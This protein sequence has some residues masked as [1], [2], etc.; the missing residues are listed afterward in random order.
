MPPKARGTMNKQ[1]LYLSFLLCATTVFGQ[2]ASRT[3]GGAVVY[4]DSL[5]EAVLAATGI[6]I[7]Q[8]DE[9]IL[10]ADVVLDEA[11]IIDEGK[12]IRLVSG[13]AIRTIYRSGNLIE[14]PVV[15]V[16]G[17]GASLTLGK[18]GMVYGLVIDGGFL[19]SPSIEAHCPLAAVSGVGAKLIMYDMVALQ[20]NKNI[21]TPS[22]SSHY[23]YGGGVYIRTEGDIQSRKAEFIMKG[24]TIRGNI[25]DVQNGLGS[26]GGV[27]I[28]GFGIF[29]MEG[30]AILNN[31]ARNTG[32]GIVI[33]GRGIFTKTGGIVYG[34][35]APAGYRNTAL[36]G[37]G[38]PKNYGHAVLVATSSPAY[39]Y[40][41]DTVG[42]NDNLSFI[43]AARGNG[44]FGKGE[45]WGN[46]DTDFRLMLFAIILLVLGVAVCVILVLRK[47]YLKKLAKITQDAADAVATVPEID[48]ENMELT[49][50]EEEI[51][52]LLLTDRNLKEI[53][54]V[55]GLTYSGANFHAQKLYTK[56]GIENRTELLVRVKK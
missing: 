42:V 7:E 47:R 19:N 24:G 20:N 48:L 15:W 36:V 25:N 22:G 51:C 49:N 56:L 26:G 27:Q 40:R 4:Y 46:P 14:F 43:G 35:N 8:P 12:H 45:K 23:E 32:G 50:R 31:I 38:V 37:N 33:G 44:S 28:T 10:L 16:R 55:L 3:D 9:I 2:V 54:A 11:L 13:N 52:E 21:G 41:N 6:S 1:I 34:A 53:S 5:H 18:P 39:Q 17:E 30:G 29:T